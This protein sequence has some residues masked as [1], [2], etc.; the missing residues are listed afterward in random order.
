MD[1]SQLSSDEIELRLA[2]EIADYETTAATAREEQSE[3]MRWSK[4]SIANAFI[5][6][7]KYLCGEC[8]GIAGSYILRRN[9]PRDF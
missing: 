5:Y 8:G 6:N 2:E 4:V 7:G 9:L 3:R 1:E